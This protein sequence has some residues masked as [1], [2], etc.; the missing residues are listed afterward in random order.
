MAEIPKEVAE[1]IYELYESTLISP[2]PF[3]EMFE[4][5]GDV[6]TISDQD[7][8]AYERGIIKPEGQLFWIRKR[9]ALAADPEEPYDMGVMAGLGLALFVITGGEPVFVEKPKS[10]KDLKEKV[11]TDKKELGATKRALA[12]AKRELEKRVKEFAKMVKKKEAQPES[13]T[14]ATK[15]DD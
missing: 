15:K 9:Q 2:V 13:A 3:E 8:H 10:V 6:V 7:K 11:S 14:K 1:R 4:V 5:K 12:S